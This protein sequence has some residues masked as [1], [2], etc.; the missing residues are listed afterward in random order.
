MLLAAAESFTVSEFGL[1]SLE[2]LH[3]VKRARTAQL[4]GQSA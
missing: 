3:K 1:E 2:G 4:E